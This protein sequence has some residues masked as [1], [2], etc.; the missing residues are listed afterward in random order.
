[1]FGDKCSGYIRVCKELKELGYFRMPMG[2]KENCKITQNTKI[3]TGLLR[4]QFNNSKP[5]I[6][7][8]SMCIYL[9]TYSLCNYLL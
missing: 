5:C 2:N 4:I 3:R 6:N 8:H 9:F 1:M 7:S